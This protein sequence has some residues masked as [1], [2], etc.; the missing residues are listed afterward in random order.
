MLFW[1]LLQLYIYTYMVVGALGR[2]LGYFRA[3]PSTNVVLIGSVGWEIL[4]RGGSPIIKALV[5]SANY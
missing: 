4:V 1:V 5:V 2:V 3:Y